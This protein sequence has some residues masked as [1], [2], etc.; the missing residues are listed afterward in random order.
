MTERPDP[1]PGEEQKPRSKSPMKSLVC[2][3]VNICAV[4]LALRA[5][6]AQVVFE[7]VTNLPGARLL[8]GVEEIRT[9]PGR[10]LFQG[11]AVRGNGF[12]DRSLSFVQQ[13]RTSDGL[14]L[15]LAE[16]GVSVSIP[17]ASFKSALGGFLVRDVASNSSFY[18]VDGWRCDPLDLQV[19]ADYFPRPD[20]IEV[21][22][23]VID[24]RN[25][26]RA[27]TVVFALP[28]NAEGWMWGDDA[29]RSR[30]IDAK[31]DYANLATVPCGATGSMSLYPL[32]A[33]SGPY[34]GLAIAIDQR[35]AAVYRV[36]Y[37]AQA[38]LLYI[39]YDFALVPDTKNFPR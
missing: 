13:G 24:F 23:Q 17:E 14:L 30:V 5:H 4:L 7:T 6:A 20:H 2:V 36:G 34:V 31:T 10:M 35:S 16:E 21:R 37:H 29:R 9:N 19:K 11:A 22:G 18:G 27:V 39:A 8:H 3:T 25:Q 26:D 33:I 15:T 28:I 32:A 12:K 38:K 1:F